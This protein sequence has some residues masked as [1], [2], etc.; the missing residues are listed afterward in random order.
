MDQQQLITTPFELPGLLGNKAQAGS[1]DLAPRL[2]PASIF[3]VVLMKLSH[4]QF[5][6]R[7]HFLKICRWIKGANMKRLIVFGVVNNAEQ[8][9]A[10]KELITVFAHMFKR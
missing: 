5:K 10:T 1:G 6:Q 8:L 9:V 7:T 2:A 4:L 3:L